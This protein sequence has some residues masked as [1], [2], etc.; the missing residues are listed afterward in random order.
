M[1][2]LA[3]MLLIF[4]A[5]TDLGSAAQTSRFIVPFLHWLNPHISLEAILLVQFLVRKAGHVTEYAILALLLLR[6]LRRQRRIVWLHAIGAWSAAA[7][8]AASD[9]WH[10]SFVSSRTASP[11]DVLLDCAGA[12]VGILAYWICMRQRAAETSAIGKWA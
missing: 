12:A 5:S 10:Q 3:W 8:Y 11:R 2:V 4:S 7:M 9:E 1:P 6:A